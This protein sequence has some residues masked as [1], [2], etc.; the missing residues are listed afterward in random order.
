MAS[1]CRLLMVDMRPLHIARRMAGG[2]SSLLASVFWTVR[3]DIAD[4]GGVWRCG[5]GSGMSDS[6]GDSFDILSEAFEDIGTSWRD[7]RYHRK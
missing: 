7:C 6:A 5:I 1:F 4:G 3:G 2:R